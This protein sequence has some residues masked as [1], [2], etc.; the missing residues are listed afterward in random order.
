MW[1]IIKLII[2]LFKKTKI[3]EDAPAEFSI[4]QYLNERAKWIKFGKP[5]RNPEDRLRIF[6]I[7]YS[8]D[9]FIKESEV[10][11]NCSICGCGIK[12]EGNMFNK[13]AWATTKCPLRKPKWTEEKDEYKSTFQVSIE[14]LEN[15]EKEHFEEL[16]APKPC[17]CH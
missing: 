4:N 3:E 5:Y 11:G 13:I 8:C 16:N 6:N 9:K 7:C 10:E 14:E 17:N 1:K 15:A 12:K 2:N